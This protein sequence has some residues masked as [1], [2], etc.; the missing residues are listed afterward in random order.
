MEPIDEIEKLEYLSLVSK[1]CTE[2]ENHLGLNDKDLAEFIIHL[3]TENPTSD[4]F[5]QALRD[6]GGELSD[7]FMDN[8]LRI[9]Q[10]MKPS[11][12]TDNNSIKNSKQNEAARKYPVLALANSAPVALSDDEE[13]NEAMSA[14]EALAPSSLQKSNENNEN[15]KS[16]KKAEKKDK[17]NKRSRSRSKS[18]ER[19]HRS[20]SPQRRRQRSRSRNRSATRNSKL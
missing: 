5:K 10:H 16:S 8:L 3:A 19:R 13:V 2:L 18:R 17:H 15:E 12:T 11:K 6:S 14:L 7:S 20:K 1:I 9:I 4:G